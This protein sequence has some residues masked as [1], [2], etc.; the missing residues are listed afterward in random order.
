MSVLPSKLQDEADMVP[1]VGGQTC[2]N[3]MNGK[4]H[5]RGLGWNW[6]WT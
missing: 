2:D 1:K 6:V 5:Q 3:G 4:L